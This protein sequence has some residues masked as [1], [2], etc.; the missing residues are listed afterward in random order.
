M[1]ADDVRLGQKLI[2]GRVSAVV[3][4]QCFIWIFVICQHLHPQSLCNLSGSLSN[5]SKANDAEG[6]SRQ[7]HQ[8]MLPEAPVVIVGPLPCLHTVRVL[9]YVVA[10]LQQKSNG[11]LRHSIRA[12][13]GDVGN[14]H[15]CRLGCCCINHIVTSGQ[16]PDEL[17]VGA[18]S[19]GLCADWGLIGINCL[20]IPNPLC[21]LVSGSSVIYGQLP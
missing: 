3:C 13:G 11:V 18:L 14:H 21:N 19:D 15:A 7:L 5:P 9:T 8:R 6:F 2:Q 4:F 1:K 20:C 12:I 16:Y 10:H 17:H